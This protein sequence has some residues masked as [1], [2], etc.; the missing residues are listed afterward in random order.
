[1]NQSMI[2]QTISHYRILSKIGQGGM[3]LV[4]KAED[5]RL[6]RVVALKF[7]P[8][9]ASE[10]GQ[11][12]ER[13]EQEARIAS[14]M[15]HPNV[16]VV[17]DIDEIDGRLFIVMEYVE[18]ETLR[19]VMN[20]HAIELDEV[21]EIA[22]TVAGVLHVAH[23]HPKGII[24]RDIKPENIMISPKGEIKVMDFGLAKAS[25]AAPITR[26]GTKMGTFR[27]A[28]PEQ[29]KGEKVDS[30]A[31]IYSLGVVI[32]E[33]AA[34][35]SPFESDNLPALIHAVLNKEPEPLSRL[36]PDVPDALEGI[37]AR[38]MAKDPDERYEDADRMTDLLKEVQEILATSGEVSTMFDP[39]IPPASHSWRQ[40]GKP[41]EVGI[42]PGGVFS[43][44]RSGPIVRG[45]FIIALLLTLCVSAASIWLY[46]HGPP[47]APVIDGPK[48]LAVMYFRNLTERTDLRWIGKG[49][50]EMLITALNQS[51]SLNVLTYDRMYAILSGMDK[52]SVYVIDENTGFDLCKE[53]DIDLMV[54]GDFRQIRNCYYLTTVL[55]DVETH[56][57]IETIDVHWHSDESK[58]DSQI[59]GKVNELAGLVKKTLGAEEPTKKDAPTSTRSLEAYADY[60]KGREA[61]QRHSWKSA[62]LP[63]E[64]ALEKD[65][66]FLEAALLLA[67]QYYVGKNNERAIRI[68]EKVTDE[69][70]TGYQMLR[71]LALKAMIEG[72]WSYMERLLLQMIDLRPNDIFSHMRLGFIYYQHKTKPDKAIEWFRKT[73]ALDPQFLSTDTLQ[74]LHYL[75]IALTL[76]VSAASIWLF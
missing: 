63:L 10:S 8:P 76:C 62:I 48:T 44:R 12:R 45:P 70:N 19:Q 66:D 67:T 50:A 54:F 13:L 5:I 1:M 40:S 35:R 74:A 27:Y 64:R 43:G 38:A 68:L 47:A 22:I 26:D 20:R 6:Q 30:R 16:A 49:I 52:E 39:T 59:L 58:I 3:G 21:L 15:T 75:G 7:L 28:P 57:K 61:A 60:L 32:Y 41:V 9:E 69:G 23:N 42:G 51:P 29:I 65:P 36:N 17:Y 37:V 14:A 4:Y 24:H 31:D 2:G 55:M 56:E 18:G 46:S 34:G 73:I 25:N 72:E 33:M 11:M 71:I 53:A